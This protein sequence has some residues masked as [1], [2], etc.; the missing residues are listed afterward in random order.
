MDFKYSSHQIEIQK[1]ARDYAQERIT[2]VVM[3][4]DESQ[5]FPWE[6][7]KELG[8]MGFLGVIFPEEYGGS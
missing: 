4:Y 1:L 7:V 6:I 5:E 2:P 8:E 3:K